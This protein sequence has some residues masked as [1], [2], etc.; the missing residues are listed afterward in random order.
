MGRAFSAAGL[1]AGGNHHVFC[2]AHYGGDAGAGTGDRF[3]RYVCSQVY[4]SACGLRDRM[5]LLVPVGYGRH[6]GSYGNRDLCGLLVPGD[7]AMAAGIGRCR[8]Y[9]SGESGGGEVLWGI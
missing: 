4:S 5:E 6:G 3:F 1:S 9:R 2:Y 7:S 8:D